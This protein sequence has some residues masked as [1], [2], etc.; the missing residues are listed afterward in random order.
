MSLSEYSC[1]IYSSEVKDTDP[2]VLCDLCEKW[3]HTDC[4]SIRE[5][6][7]GH[8]KEIPLSLYYLYCIM[9]L[10]F[11]TVQNKDLQI[12]LNDPQNNHPKAISKKMNKKTKE[13]LKKFREMS[14]IFEQSENPLTCDCYHISDFKKLK[15]NK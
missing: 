14:S 11:F 12:L 1:K 9:E 15:I 3:I 5:T 6:Q 2:A 10:P 7:Y 4:A 13:F 8:L